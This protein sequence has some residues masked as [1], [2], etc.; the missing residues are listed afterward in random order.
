MLRDGQYA[1]R[2]GAC[3]N[4]NVWKLKSYEKAILY[5]DIS[6][7]ALRLFRDIECARFSAESRMPNLDYVLDLF[8]IAATGER[9]RIERFRLSHV[10]AQEAERL[11]R[12]Y[13]KNIVVQGKRVD[14]CAIKNQVG[15]VV[16]EITQND[17]VAVNEAALGLQK[18][19]DAAYGLTA[20]KPLRR[21]H[22]A[23][24]P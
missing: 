13:V 18:E 21:P 5:C 8:A 9:E 12:A 10:S 17:I 16:K 2:G 7:T 6:A 15:V 3:L 20:V 24:R 14:L 19:E 4:D 22:R 23:L 11:A 1:R